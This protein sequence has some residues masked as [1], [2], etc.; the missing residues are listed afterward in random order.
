MKTPE[1]TAS[2]PVVSL[3]KFFDKLFWLFQQDAIEIETLGW[4][5]EPCPTMPGVELW[6]LRFAKA[7]IG[8]LNDLNRGFNQ[9]AIRIST[10]QPDKDVEFVIRQCLMIQ[11][12]CA[13]PTIAPV[14][15][16]N[17]SAADT[18]RCVAVG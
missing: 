2:I 18:K 3:Q 6:I 14:N 11:F 13:A 8:C 10:A 5:D 4:I 17:Q 15:S 9:R 1:I 7:R 12:L 16:T